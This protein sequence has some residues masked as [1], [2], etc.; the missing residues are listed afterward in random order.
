MLAAVPRRLRV[1]VAVQRRFLSVV[2]AKE[3]SRRQALIQL[4]VTHHRKEDDPER[5][6]PWEAAQNTLRWLEEDSD[7][8]NKV[9]KWEILQKKVDSI[10]KDDEPI[11]YVIGEF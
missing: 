1:S 2:E 6:N 11:A 7:C 8:S 4:L 3:Q 10:V 5:D 9:Q